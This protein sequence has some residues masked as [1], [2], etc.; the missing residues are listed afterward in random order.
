MAPSVIDHE[1]EHNTNY[2]LFTADTDLVLVTKGLVQGKHV[3]ALDNTQL[4]RVQVY[5]SAVQS[6]R[7]RHLW[8]H[9][10]L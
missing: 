10:L 2:C 6:G 5:N 3:R 1:H 7:A 4:E 8:P 9:V